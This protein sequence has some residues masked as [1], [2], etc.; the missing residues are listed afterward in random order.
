M[1]RE[2][3]KGKEEFFQIMSF[4]CREAKGW[5]LNLQ[6]TL[7]LFYSYFLGRQVCFDLITC[8]PFCLHLKML[9][10]WSEWRPG[11]IETFKC[12]QTPTPSVFQFSSVTQSCPTLCD[13]MDCSTPGLPVHHQLLEFTQTHVHWVSMPS[14]HLIF[15]RPLLLLPSTFPNI[16][17]FS[18]ELTFHIRRPKY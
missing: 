3:E 14:N 16:R 18:N 13:P 2:S 7:Y 9:L 10:R 11:I 4:L 8:V 5:W 17:V 15:C 6:T 1:K 12:S